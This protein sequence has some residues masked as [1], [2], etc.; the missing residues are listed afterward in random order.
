MGEHIEDNRLEEKFL[1]DIGAIELTE[2]HEYY[3]RNE[4]Y[5]L[6]D[7]PKDMITHLESGKLKLPQGVSDEILFQRMN[8]IILDTPLECPKCD[9]TH[10]QD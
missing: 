6:A 2:C 4:D 10:E 7:L 1:E 3:I 9:Y 8:A 5:D